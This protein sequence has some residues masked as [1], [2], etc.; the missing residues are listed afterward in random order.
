[1]PIPGAKDMRQAKENLGALG[2]RLRWVGWWVL[3]WVGV[4]LGWVGGWV[5]GWVG[6]GG[7][8]CRLR[9]SCMMADTADG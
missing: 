9:A 5:A 4:R 8:L 2:W 6:D 1:M 7:V 3:E